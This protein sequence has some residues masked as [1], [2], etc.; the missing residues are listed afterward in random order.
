M[1]H[2]VTKHFELQLVLT[3]IGFNGVP[4]PPELQEHLLQ[5]T[6][7]IEHCPFGFAADELIQL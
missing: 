5:F 2:S 4:S 6:F 7:E 3:I 1:I